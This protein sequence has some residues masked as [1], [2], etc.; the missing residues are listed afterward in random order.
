[1]NKK[2]LWLLVVV[3]LIMVG[4]FYQKSKNKTESNSIK[5]GA[6]LMMTNAGSSYGENSLN[7]A[8][9]AIDEINSNG[10]VLGKKLELV[11]EDN[12]GDNPTAAISAYN[13]LNSQGV[14]MI[15]G[16]NWT[17]SGTAIAPLACNNK[18]ILISPSLGAGSFAKTCDYVFNLWPEDVIASKSLGKYVVEKGYKKVAII[19]SL[20][21]WEKEQF[22]AVKESVVSNGGEVVFAEATPADSKDFRTQLIKI[23]KL[24]IDALV[25]TNYTNEQ[26]TAK[27]A[28]DLGINAQI[29]S[30]LIDDAKISGAS[31]A[32]EGAIAVTFFSPDQKFI[33]LYSNKYNKKP[34]VSSDSSYDVINLIAEAI[35]NTKSTDTDK[36]KKY[37]INK[38]TFEGVSGI[39]A[40]NEFG[41]MVREPY[42]YKVVSGKP[43][44]I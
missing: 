5:I 3:V 19:G 30:V 14:N 18:T 13:K 15:L 32:F 27:Q 38:K 40:F 4:G 16:T 29:F 20:Q 17:P 22:D 42:Y 2:Y 44:K 21:G 33:E 31:G 6:I 34:D 26:I 37:L 1:M 39:G 24:G 11:L 25:L 9:L 10:G 23:S 43:S 41:Q 36:I 28:R 7:G 8:N 35:N 12:Q